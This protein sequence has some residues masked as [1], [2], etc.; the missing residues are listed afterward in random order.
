MRKRNVTN[1]VENESG[2]K[3]RARFS[4]RVYDGD[5][6]NFLTI[7]SEEVAEK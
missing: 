6:K 3:R 7:P 5:R 4:N 2:R 1:K